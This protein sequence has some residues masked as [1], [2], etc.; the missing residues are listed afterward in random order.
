MLDLFSVMLKCCRGSPIMLD[1]FSVMLKCYR[2]SPIMLADLLKPGPRGIVA[3]RLDVVSSFLI[4][5]RIDCSGERNC[6]TDD[7]GNVAASQAKVLTGGGDLRE[8]VQPVSYCY[9]IP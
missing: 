1:L 3:G 7:N 5:L 9:S 6:W 4:S 8:A 2:G